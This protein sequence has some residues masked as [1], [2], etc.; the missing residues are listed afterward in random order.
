MDFL[1]ALLHLLNFLAPAVC[2]PLLLWLPARLLM[3]RPA[4][5]PRWW[6]QWL[7]QALLGTAVLVGGLLLL[8]RDGKMLTYAALVL[9]CASGQWVLLRG[10]RA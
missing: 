6:V 10:W 1:S 3:G 5:A 2:V 4:G 9:V 8:G 7:V